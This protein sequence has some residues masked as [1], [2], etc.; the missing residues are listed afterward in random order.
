MA[1][2]ELPHFSCVQPISKGN[3]MNTVGP[4]KPSTVVLAVAA[5]GV[6]GGA[7]ATYLPGSRAH[8]SAPPALIA[9]SPVGTATQP[10]FAQIAEHYGPAVVNISVSGMKNVSEDAGDDETATQQRGGPNI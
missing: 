7:G 8:A 2:F 10:D 9:P 6:L 4:F 5:A 3:N 1:K